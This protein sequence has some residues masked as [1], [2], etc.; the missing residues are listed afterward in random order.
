MTVLAQMVR[1]GC[2]V[3]KWYVMISL[4]VLR[5]A[6]HKLLQPVGR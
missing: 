3:V 4:E 2:E 6:Q 1:S 5:V